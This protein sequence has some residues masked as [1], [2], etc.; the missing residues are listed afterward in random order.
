MSS[1]VRACFHY[2]MYFLKKHC[3]GEVKF[4]SRKKDT[5]CPKTLDDFVH[6]K[7]FTIVEV[8]QICMAGNTNGLQ[9]WKPLPQAI[10]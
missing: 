5:K 9:L 10:Y 7:T 4:K 1:C 2:C 3:L 6:E 8:C